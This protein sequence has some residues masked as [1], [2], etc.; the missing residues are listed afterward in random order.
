[1]ENDASREAAIQEFHTELS[2][3]S[4][5]HCTESVKKFIVQSYVRHGRRHVMKT[6]KGFS[7]TMCRSI[8]VGG[9]GFLGARRSLW[10]RRILPA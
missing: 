9:L 2:D 5:G 7:T 3:V 8:V 6:R 10:Q 4:Y 1:M